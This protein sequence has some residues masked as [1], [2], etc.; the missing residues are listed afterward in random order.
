ML[1]ASFSMQDMLNLEVRPYNDDNYT[2]GPGVG[3]AVEYLSTPTEQD[4]ET[5]GTL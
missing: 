2:I 3:G 5:P 1:Q 4:F